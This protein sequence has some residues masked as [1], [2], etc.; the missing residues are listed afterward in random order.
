MSEATAVSALPNA[1]GMPVGTIVE[2]SKNHLMPDNVLPMDGRVVKRANYPELSKLIPRTLAYGSYTFNNLN[3]SNIVQPNNT[4]P[5]KGNEGLLRFASSTIHTDAGI[6][7]FT[8]VD[9]VN[10]QPHGFPDREPE[11]V[12]TL[13]RTRCASD[14]QQ[15]FVALGTTEP[16]GYGVRVSKDHGRSWQFIS[17]QHFTDLPQSKYS[18][19]SSIFRGY[20]QRMQILYAG[21]AF[22]IVFPNPATKT[23]QSV[24]TNLLKSEDGLSWQMI[25]G[26]GAAGVSPFPE[27]E[28]LSAIPG[29]SLCANSTHLFIVHRRQREIVYYRTCE[30]S[31]NTLVDR[32]HFSLFDAYTGS[33]SNSYLDTTA[34]VTDSA[35]CMTYLSTKTNNSNSHGQVL[36]AMRLVNDNGPKVDSSRV[37]GYPVNHILSSIS[38]E[39]TVDNGGV[40]AQGARFTELFLQPQVAGISYPNTNLKVPI[41]SS[42]TLVF[43]NP[44]FEGDV[45]HTANGFAELTVDPN[46]EMVLENMPSPNGSYLKYGI[47]AE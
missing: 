23:L 35:F 32:G 34:V 18:E 12:L 43:D 13:S 21:S 22:Y 39:L 19:T 6:D 7:Y 2:Y 31:T 5:T 46:T 30:L 33:V 3:N 45:L 41:L 29:M 28:E 24:T 44:L 26:R 14:E 20:M 1:L 16:G 9:G 4:V 47:I 8:S 11:P 15:T 37:N 27:E 40:Y 36:A 10:Y 25:G 42:A 17:L 38:S